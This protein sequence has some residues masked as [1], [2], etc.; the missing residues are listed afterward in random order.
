[1]ENKSGT[2]D[3]TFH[4]D[5]GHT[6]VPLYRVWF[7]AHWEGGLSGK[8]S[9]FFESTVKDVYELWSIAWRNIRRFGEKVDGEIISVEKIQRDSD[10][11]VIYERKQKYHFPVI[12][13]FSL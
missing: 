12:N 1:M 4:G 9:K 5:G 6:P 13:N 11:A 3:I 7:T 10:K 2:Q 8:C